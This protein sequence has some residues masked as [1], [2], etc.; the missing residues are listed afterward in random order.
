VLDTSAI[1]SARCAY[2]EQLC[3]CAR[4]KRGNKIV[5][6]CA[7]HCTCA[8]RSQTSC[9]GIACP[10]AGRRR[11]VKRCPLC[12]EAHHAHG[13]RDERR[14]A[15]YWG[16]LCGC[17]HCWSYACRDCGDVVVPPDICSCMKAG[18]NLLCFLSSASESRAIP[19]APR[20][21]ANA[22][23]PP[24][25]HSVSISSYIPAAHSEPLSKRN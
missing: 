15:G 24:R 11:S 1:S 4:A 19:I 12:E 21:E 14:R 13:A 5:R 8:C 6:V 17:W 2:K 23:V 9:Q 3:G 22:S 10:R 25:Q 18:T 7:N 16:P 20:P